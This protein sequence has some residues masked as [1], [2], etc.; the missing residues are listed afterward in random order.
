MALEKVRISDK[1]SQW[2]T[3]NFRPIWQS[4][5]K[6]TVHDIVAEK[7]MEADGKVESASWTTGNCASIILENSDSHGRLEFY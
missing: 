4:V 5:C 7:E 2:E 6:K 3:S 1:N